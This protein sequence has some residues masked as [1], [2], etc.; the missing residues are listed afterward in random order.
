MGSRASGGGAV[1]AGMRGSDKSDMQH[2]G[3]FLLL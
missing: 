1:M 2:L 3:H